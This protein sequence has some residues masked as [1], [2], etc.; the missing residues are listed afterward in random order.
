MREFEAEGIA[1]RPGADH[2]L[3]VDGPHWLEADRVRARV[4][5]YR[6][7]AAML[8][9]S[10]EQRERLVALLEREGKEFKVGASS[11]HGELIVVLSGSVAEAAE[12]RAFLEAWE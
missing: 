8:V 11:E 12:N 2:A 5:S 1:A 10:A 4:E 7:D 6:Y 3:C 9:T